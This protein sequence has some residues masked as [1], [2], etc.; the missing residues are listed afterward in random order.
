MFLN[1]VYVEDVMAMLLLSCL[2][3]SELHP[4]LEMTRKVRK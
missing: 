2:A 3:V 1:Y 4:S